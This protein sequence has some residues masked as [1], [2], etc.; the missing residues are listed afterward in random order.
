MSDNKIEIVEF[1][2]LGMV[3]NGRAFDIR[4]SSVSELDPGKVRVK[5]SDGFEVEPTSFA[6]PGDGPHEATQ[7]LTITR[8]GEEQVAAVELKLRLGSDSHA[9]PMTLSYSKDSKDDA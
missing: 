2:D 6:V 4:A 7:S 5:V 9:I 1:P 8:V 3:V